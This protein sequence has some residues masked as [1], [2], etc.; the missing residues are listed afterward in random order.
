MKNIFGQILAC[1]ALMFA[2]AFLGSEWSPT[3]FP[4]SDTAE[5]V[6]MNQEAG[7]SIALTSEVITDYTLSSYFGNYNTSSNLEL[8]DNSYV[9]REARA[10]L[11]DIPVLWNRQEIIALDQSFIDKGKTIDLVTTNE[12]APDNPDP[13]NGNDVFL[14]KNPA[15]NI[16]VLAGRHRQRSKYL[17]NGNTQ[18][19]KALERWRQAAFK[20]IVDDNYSETKALT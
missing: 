9:F 5:V 2:L 13:S 14:S 7:V 4:D 20:G 19:K 10:S 12:P 8:E 1:T 15:P 16:D 3:N 6:H 11:P 17:E 18:R